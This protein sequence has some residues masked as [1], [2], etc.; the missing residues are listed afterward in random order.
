MVSVGILTV[1][2]GFPGGPTGPLGPGGPCLLGKRKGYSTQYL[3]RGL[4]KHMLL[5]YMETLLCK[6]SYLNAR[7][8]GQFYWINEKKS[9]VVRSFQIK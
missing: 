3:L 9:V 1:G 4:R 6:N 8:N 5:P 7:L 2:P